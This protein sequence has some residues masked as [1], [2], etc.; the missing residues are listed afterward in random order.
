MICLAAF[1]LLHMRNSRCVPEELNEIDACA[2]MTLEARLDTQKTGGI[3]IILTL[4][5]QFGEAEHSTDEL[6]FRLGIHKPG[7][8]DQGCAILP[9]YPAGAGKREIRRRGNTSCS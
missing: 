4:A 9:W 6:Q 1:L 5:V 8:R 7:L 2:L 3:D